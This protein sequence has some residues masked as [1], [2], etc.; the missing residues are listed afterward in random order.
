MS[1]ELVAVC[2]NY[3]VK[4][5]LFSDHCLVT[6]SLGLKKKSKFNWEPWKLNS[7]LLQDGLVVERVKECLMLQ[8]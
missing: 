6:V 2:Y 4:A 7:R 8:L 3:D 5:Q 1:S